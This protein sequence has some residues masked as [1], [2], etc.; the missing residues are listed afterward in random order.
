VDASRV[1]ATTCLTDL[2]AESIDV[3]EIALDVEHAFSV[4]MPERSVLELATEVAGEGVFEHEGRLTGLGC[5]LLRARLP[6]FDDPALAPGLEAARLAPVFLRIDVWV[7]VVRSLLEASPRVC[8]R[9]GGGLM[10]GSPGC[11][12]CR[13]CDV[14][15]AL[16]SGDDVGRAWVRDW[17]ASRA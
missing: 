1:T 7:R 11:V 6:A 13:A 2:G 10:Q 12:T 4:L 5:E 8:A 16:P 15:L 17:L 9:C 3:V 14:E